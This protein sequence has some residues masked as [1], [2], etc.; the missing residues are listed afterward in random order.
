MSEESAQQPKINREQIVKIAQRCDMQIIPID[1][2]IRSELRSDTREEAALAKKRGQ[3]NYLKVAFP[4]DMGPAEL[5]DMIDQLSILQGRG[6]AG[7]N[8]ILNVKAKGYLLL[9]DLQVIG[10]LERLIP[11]YIAQSA[12]AVERL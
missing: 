6:K 5:G 4:A 7:H 10:Y 8:Q 11:Q 2:V 9:K 1:E 12:E 3:K